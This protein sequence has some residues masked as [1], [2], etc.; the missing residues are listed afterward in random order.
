MSKFIIIGALIAILL[1][2]IIRRFKISGNSAQT[3]L[4]K[5]NSQYIELSAPIFVLKN[6]LKKTLVTV[7]SGIILLLIIILL[8][9]KFKIILILLPISI[10]L[11][12]QFFV[13]NN[14]IKKIKS[15]RLIYDTAQHK[16]TAEVL[17]GNTKYIVLDR[18]NIKLKIVKSVQKNNGVLLGFYELYADSNKITIPFLV[19]ENLQTKPFFDKL[20]EFDRE[21][22]TKLF[23]II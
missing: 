7:A 11:I 4:S 15:Q 2:Y 8:A 13:L 19:A 9:V 14:H 1:Y 3:N 12:A 22:E 16:I 20:K 23:P 17:D 6:A 10:F 21:I 18:D 5:R